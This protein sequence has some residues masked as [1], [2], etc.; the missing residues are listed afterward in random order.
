MLSLQSKKKSLL[1][2]PFEEKEKRRKRSRACTRIVCV[3]PPRYNDWTGKP[4]K[5]T[6]F[7]ISIYQFHIG[8][9]LKRSFS[10]QKLREQACPNCSPDWKKIPLAARA[11]EPSWNPRRRR[12]F[13]KEVLLRGLETCNIVLDEHQLGRVINATNVAIN[14]DFFGYIV[15]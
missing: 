12:N 14:S 4:I 10:C 1:N 11:Q 6:R 3:C 2:H 15:L 13:N 8:R 5:I 7:T 9:R